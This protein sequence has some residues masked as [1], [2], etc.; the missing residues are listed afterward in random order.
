[1]TRGTV[2]QVLVYDGD[3]CVG[4][5]QFGS[6]TELPNINNRKT[7]DRGADGPP[8]WRIGR[9]F[10]NAKDRGKVSPP[11]RSRQRSTRSNGPEAAA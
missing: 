11:L 5:C 6:P 2:H 7:Y 4:W 3:R 8:D 1:V 9:I 10:T